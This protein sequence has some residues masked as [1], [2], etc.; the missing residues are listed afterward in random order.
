MNRPTM[1]EAKFLRD[2]QIRDAAQ[3]RLA[4]HARTEARRESRVHRLI[5]LRLAPAR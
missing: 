3:A 5:G 2:E 4:A 1:F